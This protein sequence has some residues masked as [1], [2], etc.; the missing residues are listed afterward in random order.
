VSTRGAPAVFPNRGRGSQY[1]GSTAARS[2]QALNQPCSLHIPPGRANA[3]SGRRFFPGSHS[4]SQLQERIRKARAR[5]VAPMRASRR[6]AAP[7]RRRSSALDEP[8]DRRAVRSQHCPQANLM[9]LGLA[10]RLL[11]SWHA[12]PLS[13][14]ARPCRAVRGSLRSFALFRLP[15]RDAAKLSV[16][17]REHLAARSLGIVPRMAALRHEV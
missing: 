6:R 5:L 12:G 8:S 14:R 10:F 9:L 3:R 4:L 17:R 1:L 7:G 16:R 15:W 2:A 11:S 13:L